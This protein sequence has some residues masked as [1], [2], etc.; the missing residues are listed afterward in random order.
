MNTFLTILLGFALLAVV[1][2]LV[3]GLYSFL[4][5]GEFNAKHS[6]EVMRWRVILQGVALL[7]FFLILWLGRG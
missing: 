3:F 1:G 7:I 2:A 4:R 5:G 6:N